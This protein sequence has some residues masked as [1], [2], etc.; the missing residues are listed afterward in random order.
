MTD[1]ASVVADFENP[2]YIAEQIR[3]LA[4]SFENILTERFCAEARLAQNLAMS[5]SGLGIALHAGLIELKKGNVTGIEF[6][7]HSA[8]A[9]VMLLAI[10][11]VF[12]LVRFL[13][14]AWRDSAAYRLKVFAAA[15][16]MNDVTQSLHRRAV[17]LWRQAKEM[18]KK[19]NDRDYSDPEEMRTRQKDLEAELAKMDD[20]L[21]SVGGVVVKFV[22][23]SK[24]IDTYTVA[25]EI[26]LPCLLV[27][28]LILL[29]LIEASNVGF[30]QLL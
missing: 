29:L 2:T 20:V 17:A 24:F 15:A 14:L 23:R 3:L 26:T 28:V 10:A 4:P 12:F 25:F 22:Y 8:K 9:G 27:S 13:F 11:S 16:N 30:L 7:L 1:K 21:E 19:V 5:L 18:E 6:G